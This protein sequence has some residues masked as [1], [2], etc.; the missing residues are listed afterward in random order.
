ML[1]CAGAMAAPIAID[2]DSFGPLPSATFG[3][4][5]IPNDAVAITTIQEKA[6]VADITVATITMGLTAHQRYDNPALANDGLG[7]FT[8]LGGV[9][10]KNGIEGALWNFAWDVNVVGATTYSFEVKYDFDP[11]AGTDEA[12]HGTLYLSS[13]PTGP[14]DSQ[15]LHFDFLDGSTPIGILAN[16]VGITDP[17]IGSFD[18]NASGEYSFALIARNSA[19]AEVGRSAIH[20]N[21]LGN[22]PDGGSTLMLSVLG[23]AAVA[24][25]R[26]VTR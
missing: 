19:G 26:R 20:V 1:S 15:N 22:V 14:K 9:N 3:G 25:F 17:P 13:V 24:G 8:A 5:Q 18:P 23:L 12:A 2:Y 10:V 21:V 4:T 16:L 6:A 7:T 11:A